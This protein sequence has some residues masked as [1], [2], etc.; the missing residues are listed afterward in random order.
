MLQTNA[1]LISQVLLV[2]LLQQLALDSSREPAT[3][4]E[5]LEAV[6]LAIDPSDESIAPHLQGIATQARDSLLANQT[7]F[8]TQPKQVFTKFRALTHILVSLSSQQ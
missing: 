5:W 2:S 3:K 8:S 6:A 4:L 7:V 1:E